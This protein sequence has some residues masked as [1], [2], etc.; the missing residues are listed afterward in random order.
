MI[1]WYFFRFETKGLLTQHEKNHLKEKKLLTPKTPKEPKEYKPRVYQQVSLP[2]PE[3]SEGENTP[4]K[5]KVGNMNKSAVGVHDNEDGPP[6]FKCG[7]ICRDKQHY[8]NHVLSHY[9]R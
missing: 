2:K 4:S 5:L 8:K 9:Y 3:E 1:S 6:C 7:A